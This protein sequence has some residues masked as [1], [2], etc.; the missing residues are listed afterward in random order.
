MNNLNSVLIEGNLVHDPDL[1]KTENGTD[2]CTFCLSTKRYFKEGPEI[3]EEEC[4]FNVETW[5]ELAAYC[6]KSGK[7]N[8]SVRVV[9]RLKQDWTTF[10][11]IKIPNIYIVAEH[12]EFRPSF[13]SAD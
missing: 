9:G 2:L 8:Q 4:L 7:K 5:D 3:K 13:K 12:V 6:Q 11:E 10:H 1:K